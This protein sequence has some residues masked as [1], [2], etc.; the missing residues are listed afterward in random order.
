MPNYPNL[1][2]LR[3]SRTG[4]PAGGQFTLA[5]GRPRRPSRRGQGVEAATW[6]PPAGGPAQRGGPR[7]PGPPLEAQ[8]P[9]QIPKVKKSTIS[10]IERC[11]TSKFTLNLEISCRPL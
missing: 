1:A 2:L 7:R 3:R 10:Y 9:P 5:V 8:D 11:G 6:R 4:R